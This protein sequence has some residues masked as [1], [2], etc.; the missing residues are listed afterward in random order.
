MYFAVDYVVAMQFS[1]NLRKAPALYNPR[2][3]REPPIPLAIPVQIT[4]SPNQSTAGRTSRQSSLVQSDQFN[5]SSNESDSELFRTEPRTE[6]MMDVPNDLVTTM[7]LAMA[8]HR[9]EHAVD[10]PNREPNTI[11]QTN[12]N[13][14]PNQSNVSDQPNIENTME[15]LELGLETAHG[16][17]HASHSV[18][19]D[20]FP[21]T[22]FADN[23][24]IEPTEVLATNV[25]D[26]TTDTK[27]I[28][29]IHQYELENADEIISVLEESHEEIYDDDVLMTYIK[30]PMPVPSTTK[31]LMKREGDVVSGNLP[32]NNSVSNIS[33]SHFYHTHIKNIS[34]CKC[35]CKCKLNQKQK[36]EHFAQF[37]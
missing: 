5:D 20:A 31:G 21:S 22:S 29:P 23:S 3:L 27:P 15:G 6:R 35:E 18:N 32:F 25:S 11:D 2:R 34:T 33:F 16:E 10:E 24:V 8:E 4:V 14:D 26:D 13:L 1:N 30:F 19:D 12:P 9:T 7:A 37:F 17:A 36:P 28:V